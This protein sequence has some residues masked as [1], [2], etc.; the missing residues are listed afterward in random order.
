MQ[1]K[2][3][4]KNQLSAKVLNLEIPESGD[5]EEVEDEEYMEEE[6]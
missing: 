4:E 6:A 3:S 5:E 2:A 1:A